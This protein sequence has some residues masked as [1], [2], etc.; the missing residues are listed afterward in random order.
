MSYSHLEVSVAVRE[1][2]DAYFHGEDKLL[3]AVTTK[4]KDLLYDVFDLG[5][6]PG[7]LDYFLDDCKTG[8]GLESIRT[9]GKVEV[10][11]YTVDFNNFGGME[12]ETPQGKPW[13]GIY[14]LSLKDRTDFLESKDIPGLLEGLI[15]A[16]HP[17]KRDKEEFGEYAASVK[18]R[19]K[20][21]T[22]EEIAEFLIKDKELAEKKQ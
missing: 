22:A 3:K 12:I 11:G 6:L 8:T 14:L 1:L 16:Q 17:D 18:Y 10:G 21:R 20:E 4:Y 15:F 5:N 19:Y 7:S 2:V 13:R 9:S